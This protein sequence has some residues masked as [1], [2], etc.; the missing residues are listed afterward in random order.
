[1]ILLVATANRSSRRTSTIC[2]SST[3]ATA[4]RERVEHL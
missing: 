1:V 3:P 4:C 2:D